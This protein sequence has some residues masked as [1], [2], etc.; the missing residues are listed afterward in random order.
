MLPRKW[1]PCKNNI[2]NH[3]QQS[4]T[5]KDRSM[6]FG[7][8]SSVRCFSPSCMVC[9]VVAEQNPGIEQHQSKDDDNDG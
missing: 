6:L 8:V 7:A 4:N 5:F 3:Q 9:C 2:S 1:R